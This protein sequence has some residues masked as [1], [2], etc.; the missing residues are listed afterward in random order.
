MA[1]STYTVERT[2]TIQAPAPEVYP[3][4]ADFRRWIDWSP[5]EGMDPDMTREYSGAESGPGAV[6]SW[7]GNR[8]AGRG[9]MEITGA[10]EPTHVTID[11][12]FEKPFRS[13]SE[14]VFL[15][16]PDGPGTKVT[17]RMTGPSTVMTKV[18]GLFTSMDSMIGP[19]FEKG[20]ER[21]RGVAES[22]D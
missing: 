10:Q 3:H 12:R 2:L 4:I 18:M 9:R 11:L 7:S 8:K 15:L 5:W 17:W 13:S 14:T 6:Y 22:P 20:L 19:D 16:E 21:L 1:P